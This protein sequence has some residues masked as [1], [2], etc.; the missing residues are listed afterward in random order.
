MAMAEATAKSKMISTTSREHRQ[1]P[2]VE[3]RIVNRN[4]D[5]GSEGIQRELQQSEHDDSRLQVG[6]FFSCGGS[7]TETYFRL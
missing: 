6:C 2:E 5:L 4:L 1:D 3:R 7:G